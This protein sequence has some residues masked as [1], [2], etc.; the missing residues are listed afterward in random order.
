M[1]EYVE[2]A[3]RSGARIIGTCCGSTPDHIAA[4]RAALD[5][6]I[7]GLRPDR[8]EIEARLDATAVSEPAGARRGGRRRR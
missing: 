5:A 6:G 1:A 2:L 8:A 4:V 3:V 7:E